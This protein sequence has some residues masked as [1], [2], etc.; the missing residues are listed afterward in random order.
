LALQTQLQE[1]S[2]SKSSTF[3]PDHLNGTESPANPLHP[4]GKEIRLL[5]EK[6]W[7]CWPR[8]PNPTL[9]DVICGMK[10]IVTYTLAGS[11]SSIYQT[12]QETS[13][14]KS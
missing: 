10:E 6:P 8:P 11:L 2:I 12:V 9:R 14:Q 13:L 7:D 3:P 1:S 4:P 5:L